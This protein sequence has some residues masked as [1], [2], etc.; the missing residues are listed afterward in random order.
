MPKSKKPQ[1]REPQT[2]IEAVR[3]FAD[4]DVAT[5]FVARLRWP[6]G[7]M[8]PRCGGKDYS[9]LTSRRLW[10]CRDCKKQYSVK[11]GSIF[12]DSAIKLDKWLVSIWLIAN[13]KNGI[14]SHELARATGLTQKTAWFVLHRIRLAMQT[15]TFDKL[16]GEVEADETYIGGRGFNMHKSKKDKFGGKRGIAVN[17]TAVIGMR[18]RDGQVIANV[19]PNTKRPTLQGEVRKHVEPGTSLY[20]DKLLSYTGLEGDYDHQVIDHAEAYVRGRVHTNGMENFWALLK[21]GLKGTYVQADADHLHRYVD[22]QVYRYNQREYSDAERFLG[23]L[24]SVAG[25]RLTWADLTGK[26]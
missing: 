22:E 1:A 8:C 12:E 18:Q 3:Y 26:A 10:K 25:R 7:P 9:Y 19:V 6:G 13:A 20:T 24:A 2:L 21:R 5:Q 16:S 11:L 14:S 23:V 4:I 17:K 15:G